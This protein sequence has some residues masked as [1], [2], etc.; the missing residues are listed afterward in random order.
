MLAENLE[1][2]PAAVSPAQGS[3]VSSSAL[4]FAP[5]DIALLLP[6]SLLAEFDAARS[7]SIGLGPLRFMTLHQDLL[8][9]SDLVVNLEKIQQPKFYA[10]VSQVKARSL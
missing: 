10:E 8:H 1:T 6:N 3:P 5:A 9:V 4:R 2:S 7:S